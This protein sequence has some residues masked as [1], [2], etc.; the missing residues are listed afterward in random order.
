MNILCPTVAFSPRIAC[1]VLSFGSL[2]FTPSHANAQARVPLSELPNA[3]SQG[4]VVTDNDVLTSPQIKPTEMNVRDLA[5]ESYKPPRTIDR[6]FVAL[7]ALQVLAA[8]ADAETTLNCV[9]SPHCSEVNPILGSHPT[10][11]RMYALAVPLTA[12]SVFVSY[13]YKRKSPT[14][15]WWKVYPLTLSAIHTF[16]AVNNL[17]AAHN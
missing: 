2:A 11:G 5:I 7:N 8:I 17:A 15:G 6:Q 12:L 16:G 13:H 10:R 14:K 1:L 9:S 3:P 4:L